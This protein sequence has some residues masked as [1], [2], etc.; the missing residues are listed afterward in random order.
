MHVG[1]QHVTVSLGA[2]GLGTVFFFEHRPPGLG[3]DGIDLGQQLLI[4]MA[5]VLR[6]SFVVERLFIRRGH[7]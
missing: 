5:D 6:K 7:R 2:D 1:L 4:Q 3:D